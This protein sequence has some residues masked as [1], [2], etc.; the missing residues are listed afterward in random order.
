MADFSMTYYYRQY[1][2]AVTE[3]SRIRSRLQLLKEK[4]L[5]VSEAEL[6]GVYAEIEAAEAELKEAGAEVDRLYC[7]STFGMTP[8]ELQQSR[9]F[10]RQGLQSTAHYPPTPSFKGRKLR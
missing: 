9:T 3:L 8:D 4:P 5:Y 7:L 6:P 1:Q 2:D 10:R